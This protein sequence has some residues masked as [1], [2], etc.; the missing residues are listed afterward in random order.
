MVKDQ[1]QTEIRRLTCGN[2]RRFGEQPTV[3]DEIRLW[4]WRASRSL[5]LPRSYV[6][7]SD[8]LFGMHEVT[9]GPKHE[10]CNSRP[11]RVNV[12]VCFVR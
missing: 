3:A 12:H 10:I 9:G 7:C 4:E 8:F 6:G 2:E 11:I 1:R 5:F